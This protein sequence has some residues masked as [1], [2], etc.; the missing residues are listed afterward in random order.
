MTNGV[1]SEP[2][3]FRSDHPLVIPDA[4]GWWLRR[5]LRGSNSPSATG[6]EFTAF[7]SLFTAM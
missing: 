4:F 1:P 7:D 3:G 6:T 5:L 2:A